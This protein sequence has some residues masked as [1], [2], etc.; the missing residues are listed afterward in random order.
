MLLDSDYHVQIADFGLTRLA[1]ATATCSGAMSYHFAAPELFGASED[2][3]ECDDE[4]FLMRKTTRSDVYAFACLFY[5]VCHTME[6]LTS[7]SY[8]TTCPGLLQ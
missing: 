1:D 4:M 6:L 7:N 2:E 5:E 3:G 8:A